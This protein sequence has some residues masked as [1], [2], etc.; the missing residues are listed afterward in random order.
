MHTG[1]KIAR[2]GIT[3]VRGPTTPEII[4]CLELFYGVTEAQA[5]SAGIAAIIYMFV[6]PKYRGLG[7]GELALEAI[8]AIHVVQGC[9]FTVLV[10]DD[11]GNGKLIQWYEKN[12]FRIAPSLQEVFGSSQGLG[13][14]MIRPVNVA[15]DIFSRCTIKYW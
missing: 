3:T 7:I 13:M 10:A 12:G 4:S 9:D 2:F 15:P 1:S 6:E 8:A 14:A 11:K 5:R